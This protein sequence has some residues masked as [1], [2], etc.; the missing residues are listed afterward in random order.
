MQWLSV[1][2]VEGHG[3]EGCESPGGRGVGMADLIWREEEL[4][5][6]RSGGF[7]WYQSFQVSDLPVTEKG[8]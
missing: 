4:T 3:K 7:L 8:N 2:T 6:L 5:E 1:G